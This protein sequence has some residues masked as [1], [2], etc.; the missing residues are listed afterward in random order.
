MIDRTGP[1]EPSLATDLHVQATY[2]LTEALVE[3]ENRMRRRIE[4]LSEIVFETDPEGRLVFLNAAWTKVLGYPPES[5]LGRPLSQYVRAEDRA[6]FDEAMKGRRSSVQPH[7]RLLRRDGGTAWMEVSASHLARG[8]AVGALRDVSSEK[9]ALDELAK[10]SLVASYT[11]NLVIITD[12][13]GCTE[14]VNQAF[15]KRTGYTLAEMIGQKPGA[16][17]QGPETDLRTVAAVREA[18]ANGQSFKAELLNYTCRGEAYW[19]SFQITP[20]RD[21]A[22]R[23]ERFVSIQADTTELHRTQRDLEV[24]K[25]RAEALAVKAQAAN[26]AKSE[27]L[28]TMSHEIRTP[29]NAILGMTE[30][31]SQT[32][33]DPRQRELTETVSQSGNAL[34]RTLSDILDFS[35]IEAA[36][37]RLEV[38][39]F[40]VRRLVSEVVS[41][42]AQSGH[43]KPVTVAA[44]FP[45]D[46]PSRAWGDAGRLRQVLMNLVGNALKFTT[47][48]SVVVRLRSQPDRS[49]R[50]RLRFEVVDTGM[51]IS[52]DKKELL[53][54]PFQQV[55]SSSAR[56]HGGTG[57]GLVISSR[58]VE[59]M[60]GR[61]GVESVVGQG[62]VFWFELSLPVTNG[63]VPAVPEPALFGP[64]V[65][66]VQEPDLSRR[67]SL[68]YLKK[69]G[70]QTDVAG[71]GTEALEKLRHGKFTV[72][73]FSSQLRD[74][75][76][77]SL[78]TAIQK[79]A[80]AHP[81]VRLIA[82]L[83]T[84]AMTAAEAGLLERVAAVVVNPPSLA[85][86]RRALDAGAR[87]GG[88]GRP[89]VVSA[90]AGI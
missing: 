5:C 69:L 33:L 45:S 16:I 86:F 77:D 43:G 49:G 19:V 63:A 58:L 52:A 1:T 8:G 67:I 75:E 70:C 54:Q 36:E 48:G 71:S 13:H 72:V 90:G 20:I 89:G 2:R 7:V 4:L 84:E 12:R 50:V 18:V 55:D 66:V 23:V 83:A 46:L 53:F 80:P 11:D 87:R 34:L 42:V 26:Q 32:P 76:A 74:M 17:L 27:F 85:Q 29:L 37:V 57:L 44:E 38:E 73:L 61:M 47:V 3:S 64:Q 56:R 78:V 82:S 68:L 59:L 9:K 10:L 31:L 81:P 39:A 40:E 21:A 35:Q 41:Q 15:T 30:L 65:L 79:M 88:E 24:A 6:T 22:G 28:A 51:G 62:S 25:V 14:W 60:D